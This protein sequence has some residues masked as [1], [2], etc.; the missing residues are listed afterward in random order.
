MKDLNY[1]LGLRYRIGLEQDEDGGFV[2]HH[3]E[4]PGCVAQGETPDEAVDSLRAARELWIEVRLEDGLSVPEPKPEI[5][6]SG[7]FLV[8]LPKSL[9]AEL[10]DA[11]ESDGSSLNQLVVSALSRYIASRK[12]ER[13]PAELQAIWGSF[14]D[15]MRSFL[16]SAEHFR[17]VSSKLLYAVYNY[18]LLEWS[19]SIQGWCGLRQFLQSELAPQRRDVGDCRTGPHSLEKLT[20]H[21]DGIPSVRA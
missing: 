6:Y 12:Q 13:D 17:P 8:R 3:P 7:K 9:H 14:T 21:T 10:A 11:A 2:A 15:P 5:H 20:D 4:L 19:P 18:N 16:R 1:F